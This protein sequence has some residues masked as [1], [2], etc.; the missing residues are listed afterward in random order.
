MARRLNPYI[1][2]NGNA[3]E[4]MEFYKSVFGG[5]LEIQT[6]GEVPEDVQKMAGNPPKD[7]V[8]HAKLEADGITILAS[9]SPKA[10][11]KTSKVELSIMGENES[12]LRSIYEKLSQGGK[13]SMPLQKQFWGDIFGTL[14]DKYGVDWMVNIAQPG[15]SS[16]S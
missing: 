15:G 2:F 3:K 6:M 12:D 8:M 5:N 1:F 13:T 14:T 16:M 4:A 10:S 9:D 11:S 7:N